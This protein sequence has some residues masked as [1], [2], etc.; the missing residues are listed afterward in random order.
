[1]RA[2]TVL[3]G[4]TLALAL[5]AAG[6]PAQEPEV[7]APERNPLAPPAGWWHG[8]FAD[9]E[10]R[11]VL[12]ADGAR[13]AGELRVRGVTWR[14]QGRLDDEGQLACAFSREG[15]PSHGLVIG[16]EDGGRTLVLVSGGATRRLTRQSE[17]AQGGPLAH[18]R[19]G[20]RWLYEMTA[21][22]LRLR[23]VYEV[24]EVGAREVKCRLRMLMQLPGETEFSE[25]GEPTPFE[26][27]VPEA[28]QPGGAEPPAGVKTRRERITCA[29]REWDC[30]VTETG[31]TTCWVPMQGDQPTF[32]P[33][34]KLV[35]DQTQA[36]LVEVLEPPPRK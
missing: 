16:A 35:S 12:H 30:L 19:P 36:E 20:Q 21:S 14:V 29:G 8:L 6:A 31:G 2:K 13:V 22:G 4:V 25:Q 23:Q 32:P 1:M 11:L 28:A 24:L 9:D 10:V 5:L 3:C 15:G 34:L 18:V 17:A 27:T 33:Y 7:E 26:W